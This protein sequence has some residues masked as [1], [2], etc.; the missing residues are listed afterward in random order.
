MNYKLDYSDL[1]VTFEPINHTATYSDGDNSNNTTPDT[2]DANDNPNDITNGNPIL[3][4]GTYKWWI[5]ILAKNGSAIVETALIPIVQES[6]NIFRES[7]LVTGDSST[8]STMKAV[9]FTIN[10]TTNALPLGFK[11]YEEFTP[12]GNPRPN[13]KINRVIYSTGNI[14]NTAATNYIL[15]GTFAAST[16]DK[17][18]IY[19]G[20]NLGVNAIRYRSY[21]NANSIN[22]GSSINP[23]TEVKRDFAN[24]PKLSTFPVYY[25]KLNPISSGDLT[26]KSTTRKQVVTIRS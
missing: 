16:E 14:S 7:Y 25:P 26:I 24:R 1:E 3:E 5:T 2:R 19:Y 23:S 6:G 22:F 12:T 9:K 10:Q 17:T 8:G 13:I 20:I 15:T 11:I 4:D 21:K 18:E